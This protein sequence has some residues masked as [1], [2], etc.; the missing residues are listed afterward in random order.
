MDQ[1][2]QE[3]Q[4]EEARAT[5]EAAFNAWAELQ[6]AWATSI[7]GRYE[8]RRGSHNVEIRVRPWINKMKESM[9]VEHDWRNEAACRFQKREAEAAYSDMMD[10]LRGTCPNVDANGGEEEQEW[11]RRVDMAYARMKELHTTFRVAKFDAEK[12]EAA[13]KRTRKAQERAAQEQEAEHRRLAQEQQAAH[14]ARARLAQE[15]EPFHAN[16][17]AEGEDSDDTDDGEWD[18][19]SGVG[20]AFAGRLG[21]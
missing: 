16:T 19:A 6:R 13:M 8:T 5:F 10:A 11:K 15:Q 1:L 14:R 17:Y 18:P 21:F 12:A 7:V 20:S 9:A 3:A 2:A 4:V